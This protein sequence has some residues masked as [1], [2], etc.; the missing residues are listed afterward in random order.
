MQ[1][2]AFGKLSLALLLAVFTANF[3]FGALSYFV[4][5]THQ[6]E[7]DGNPADG[8]LLAVLENVVGQEITL[9]ITVASNSLTD[10]NQ[11]FWLRWKNPDNPTLD[12]VDIAYGSL[13]ASDLTPGDTTSSDFSGKWT[14]PYS[15]RFTFAI[16]A[17][18]GDVVSFAIEV[19]DV[20]AGN[21]TYAE[22]RT[23][24]DG[25]TLSVTQSLMLSANVGPSILREYISVDYYVNG[26]KVNSE[27]VTTDDGGEFFE[28]TWAAP[29]IGD[30]SI[31]VR[32]QM[33]NGDFMESDEVYVTLVGVGSSPIVT[34]SAPAGDNW[35]VGSDAQFTV[36][37]SDSGA[38][39]QQIDLVVNG[40]IVSSIAEAWSVSPWTFDFKFPSAGPYDVWAIAQFSNGNKAISNILN[41]EL[42]L[43]REPF[44]YLISPIAGMQFLPGS[45]LP[46]LAS[47][48]DPN[49]L[50]ESLK[51]YV[52]D[53]LIETATRVDDGSFD[54]D[55]ITFSYN[56]PFAG[57]Y[58]IYVQA[59]DEAGVIAQSE[60]VQ[61]V[62]RDLDSR[63]PRV[64]MSHPLP[65]GGGDTVNDVSVGSAMYLNAIATDGDGTIKKVNF[66]IN[67]QL[68]GSSSA[69]YNDTYASYFAPT[70]RGNY[71]M[72]AEAVDNSGN[73]MHSPPLLLNVYSLEAQ[74]PKVKILPLPDPYKEFD[75]GSEISVSVEVDGGLVTVNQINYYVD[76]VL[77]D[78]QDTANEDDA[79]VFTASFKVESP[80]VHL[81][82]ARAIEIDP[83][84]L[85]TDNWSIADPVGIKVNPASTH[86]AFVNEVYLSMLGTTPSQT[87]LDDAVYALENGQK[88]QAQYVYEL[89]QSGVFSNTLYALM[90]RYL[91]TGDW[92]T[93]NVLLS[94]VTAVTASL[95]QFV[96]VHLSTFQSKYWNNQRIPDGFST[97][98]EF[99]NF[100]KV[101]FQNKYGKDPTSAQTDRGVMQMKVFFVEDFIAEFVRDIEAT[102]FGSGTISTILGIPNPPNS[103]LEDRAFAASLYCNL[104]KVKPTVEEVE[105]LRS[106]TK[107][108]QIQTVLADPRF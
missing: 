54:P 78:S 60:V 58:R 32:A 45:E 62:V 25:E 39:V 43:G 4:E 77:V 16:E 73:R 33:A 51:Y 12:Q 85:T 84:G 104:L 48:W 108:E 2:I 71:V 26:Y 92:P 107:L 97:D 96:T 38:L 42:E 98:Q 55:P 93:R 75:A 70:T 74:L 57:T 21:L 89:M 20:E 95:A 17:S 87:V 82:S 23:P 35:T 106:K 64:V 56:F 37:A 68:V 31:M 83:L 67:S 81:L 101:L 18:G 15:G 53:T 28:Y 9:K 3:G 76:G 11:S 1:R 47:A 99:R 30:V 80:G 8:S 7:M 88:T 59:T 29:Y 94:D 24:T 102:A 44:V 90:G 34:L 36:Q 13:D 14:P 10:G 63:I 65:V 103:L 40:H 52:N 91:L 50:I 72:F 61:V 6:G 19:V 22:M 41:Y 79:K 49:S 86:R 5:I 69:G 66:Y 27:P 105:A 46:I 100:F